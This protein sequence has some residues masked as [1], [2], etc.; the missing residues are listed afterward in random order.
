MVLTRATASN[1]RSRA[2][3]PAIGSSVVA[4][5][6]SGEA[7]HASR[8]L[9]MKKSS[10]HAR[11][12]GSA[13]SMLPADAVDPGRRAE[14]EDGI[15]A[16]HPAFGPRVASSLGRPRRLARGGRAPAVDRRHYV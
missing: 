5:V 3:S 1:A 10:I 14:V 12:A 9:W 11:S 2:R 4:A 6:T 15:S 13:G 8:A 16:A 7:P